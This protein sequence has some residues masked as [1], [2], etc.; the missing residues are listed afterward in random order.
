M[1]CS[2]RRPVSGF[3]PEATAHGSL[4]TT[5][6]SNVGK[7]FPSAARIGFRGEGGAAGLNLCAPEPSLEYQAERK[8][9]GR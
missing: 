6:G 5:S 4:T 7:G 9:L 8:G 2:D 1:T 3:F